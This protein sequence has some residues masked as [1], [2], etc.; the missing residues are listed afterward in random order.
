MEYRDTIDNLSRQALLAVV[1]AQ[2]CPDVTLA[3]YKD[4]LAIRQSIEGLAH[5]QWQR[6][7]FTHT[8]P[9]KVNQ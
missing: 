1:A 6:D 7:T 2:D 9:E 4:L 8:I 3:E 5:K